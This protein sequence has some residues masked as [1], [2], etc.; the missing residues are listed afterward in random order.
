MTEGSCTKEN[1]EKIESE[2]NPEQK[3]QAQAQIESMSSEALES[4]LKQQSPVF[5]VLVI[6]PATVCGYSP[7]LRLDL[8]VNML[9]IQALVT[10]KITVFGG[11]QQRPNIHIED[12]TDL[13]VKTLEYSTSKISGKIYNCGYENYPLLYIAQMIQRT[14]KDKRIQINISPIVDLRSYRISSVKLKKELGFTPRHSLEEAVIDLQTAYR[15][16]KIPQ[17]QTDTR[18]YNIQTLKSLKLC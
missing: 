1:L 10:G 13:Y 7:R 9:T 4:L 11:T 3:K 6:R 15:Q 12:I 5:C 14:L 17:A 16:G 2:L 8:T 18:Y